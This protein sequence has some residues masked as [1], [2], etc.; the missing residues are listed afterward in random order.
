VAR[1]EGQVE[2]KVEVLDLAPMD[3]AYP[4]DVSP[5]GGHFAAVVAKG[6]RVAVSVDGVEGPRFDEILATG[7][8]GGRGRVAFSPDGSR[9]AYVARLGQEF[10][11]MV[12][13][14]EMLR[15]PV[16]TSTF[17]GPSPVAGPGFTANG[18]H[19]YFV[20]YTHLSNGSGENY[21]QFVYDGQPGPRTAEPP[22]VFLSPSGDRYAYVVTNP[23]NRE[24]TALIVDGKPAAYPAAGQK[25]TDLGEGQGFQ[26]TADGAHLFVKTIPPRG[27]GVD[28]LVDGRA[29]MRAL[30]AQLYMAPVG[31]VFATVVT[32]GAPGTS[33]YEQFVDIGGKPV[34]GSS[35]QAIDMLV[36]SP[37]A[38]HWAARVTTAAQSKFVIA[39][40]RKGLEYQDVRDIDF[41]AAGVVVYGAT[42]A[43]KHFVVVGDEESD[44]FDM[45]F[46][47]DGTR[48]LRT[49]LIAGNHVGFSAM[50]G[51]G[52][53]IVVDG[54]MV[55]RQNAADLALSPDGSR[56]A[57]AFAGG[58]NVD[59]TDVPGF[60]LLT[61]RRAPWA[62]VT[63]QPGRFLWSPDSRHLVAFGAPAGG[64]S[65]GV[66]V[67]GKYFAT[68]GPAAWQPYS[69][70]F[71]PDG[72]HLTWFDRVPED[73]HW[74]VFIDGK[75][76]V[77]VDDDQRLATTPGTW[78]MGADGVLTVIGRLDGVIKRFR[79]TPGSD[80]SIETLLSKAKGR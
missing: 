16:A 17:G 36:F 7:A 22:R 4:Y 74:V 25:L 67:D 24:Q 41:T 28:V 52:F 30:G 61:F 72:R 75:P 13:G 76:T 46:P 64:G 10:V 68:G 78:E 53:A 44:A 73:P 65:R 12:D 35:G 55:E 26:F 47:P 38:K 54:K 9:Y 14:K 5:H 15:A 18:K 56:F 34:P 31:N 50:R 37:D 69:P 2:G 57:F 70:L 59:G 40:G 19:I 29:F 49:F 60:N 32:R 20:L 33:A 71:T 79:I 6:S 45:I 48:P 80:T 23:S 42:N 39:D 62:N 63:P 77:K 21:Y 58:Y 51:G 27:V 8:S 66:I 43:N 11:V 1:A 3:P